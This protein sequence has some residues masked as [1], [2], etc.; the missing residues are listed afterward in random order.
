MTRRPMTPPAGTKRVGMYFR[1]SGK[2]QLQGYSLDAQVRAIEAYCA[3]QRWEIVARYPEPARSARKDNEATRPAFKQ[4]LADAE[5]GRFDVVVVHKLDRFARNRRVAFDAFHQLGTSGVGF[6]SVAENMD[7][8]TPAGQL[9][10][11]MLVGMA[12]FYSDNLAW[13]IKKGKGERKAQGLYNGLLPFGTTLDAQ[14]VPILDETPR[15]C[16][17]ATRTEIV[18]GAGLVYAFEL[19]AAGQTDREIARALNVAG[20]R[21]SGNRGANPFTKDTVRVVLRNRFY[22]GELPDGEGGSVPGKHGALIDPKLFE[23]AQAARERNTDNPR[24]VAGVRQPWGLSGVATCGSCGASITALSHE[25]GQRRVRCAGRTQGN[26]CDEPSCYASVIE[27]QIGDLLAGFAVPEAEQ[28][29]LIAVWRSFHSP[30]KDAATERRRL[31]RRLERVRE[32]Y[33]EG[34]LDKAAY[35]ARRDALNAQL[36]ALPAEGNASAAVGTRLAAY[37]ADVASGWRAATPEERNKL[38]RQLFA[39]V[40]VTN[41]TAVAVVPRPD[42]RPFFTLVA[43]NPDEKECYGGSD[44]GR[45]RHRVMNTRAPIRSASPPFRRAA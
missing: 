6:V 30:S 3:Q 43:V 1:V 5:A 12:Q 23:A 15:S 10:L 36:A 44:G 2:E 13:E 7:Y 41:R 25:S 17:V 29:R 19:A 24:R 20:Y 32:L 9:M 42:L 37:L 8:S 11:T 27:D 39:S 22:I 31:M 45:S 40:V 33:L 16:A 28:Q 35:Q 38:A 18:P 14:G 34:D 26:G 21:T 4:L